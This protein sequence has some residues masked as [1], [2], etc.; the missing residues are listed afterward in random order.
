MPPLRTS[1]LAFWLLTAF[2]APLSTRAQSPSSPLVPDDI[3][4]F[5]AEYVAAVNAKD[6]AKLL[7]FLTPETRSCANPANKDVYDALFNIQFD[8]V[9]P[10]NYIARALARKRSQN[11][12]VRRIAIFHDSA[13]AGTS[14]QLSDWG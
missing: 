4:S 11:K 8:D 1:A 9:I 12:C 6:S 10:P 2:A 13:R 14:N 7:S 5:A 3:R